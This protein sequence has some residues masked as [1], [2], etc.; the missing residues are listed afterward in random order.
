QAG[1]IVLHNQPGETPRKTGDVMIQSE[2]RYEV[3]DGEDS[4]G[5]IPSGHS[6][7]TLEQAKARLQEL[8]PDFPN[9]FI[10]E[11]I[12]TRLG[13]RNPEVH[14]EHQTISPAS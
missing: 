5:F 2:T 7:W 1:R 6:E 14:H 11:V 4:D 9:S 3:M 13:A 12:T 8:L 10:C